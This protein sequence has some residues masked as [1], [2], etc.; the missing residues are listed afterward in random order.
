MN[1]QLHDRVTDAQ[2]VQ[3]RKMLTK[4]HN[5][6]SAC[7]MQMKKKLHILF[8]E[9][10]WTSNAF[11]KWEREEE[12]EKTRHWDAITD[13]DSVQEKQ[14]CGL[15]TLLLMGAVQASCE[16]V[17]ISHFT[18]PK[19][20]GTTGMGTPTRTRS[21]FL[22]IGASLIPSGNLLEMQIISLKNQRL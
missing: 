21:A 18:F 2:L 22:N 9:T 12:R 16:L 5:W 10:L 15:L 7:R 13:T 8:S 17:A 20:T 3:R 6:T 4:M 1:P 11:N 19:A 14:H